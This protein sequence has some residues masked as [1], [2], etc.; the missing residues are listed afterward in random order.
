MDIALAQP[1]RSSKLDELEL[2]DPTPES[3]LAPTDEDLSYY[4]SIQP[5][6]NFAKYVNQSE[7]LQNFIKLGVNLHK[8]EKNPKN[9]EPFLHL[10]FER[11]VKKYIT[12]LSDYIQSD[13]LGE[14]ISKNPQIFFQDMDNLQ[15]RINYLESKKFT[16]DMIKR[17]VSKN[18]FWLMFSTVQI[19]RRL[20]MFQN[21]F[22]LTGDEVRLLVTKQPRLITF[23]MHHIKVNTFSLREEM[24]FDVEE[25]KKMILDSP[26]ILSRNNL[27]IIKTFNYIHSVMKMSHAT[28]ASMP[29][30]LTQKVTKVKERHSF[31]EKL[32]RAQYDCKKPNYVN[33]MCLVSFSDANFCH[34][35]A[36]CT[37]SEYDLYLKSI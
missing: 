20:G 12:F 30:V 34:E 16:I 32:G 29:C 6:F 8:I 14:F 18:P 25:L 31:L 3:L 5:T 27:S 15:T 11:D 10:D 35:I 21:E 23:S 26:R 1:V 22:S 19:D 13:C 37:L 4:G 24:G 2:E 9:I 17:I 7:T 28:I 36:K 33:L